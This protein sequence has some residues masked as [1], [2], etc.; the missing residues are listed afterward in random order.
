MIIKNANIVTLNDT[1]IGSIN[2][3]ETILNIDKGN[4]NNSNA[5][6]FEGD[7]LLPG[8]IELHTDNLEK[9]FIPRPNAI[10]PNKI[11]AAIA[12]DNEIV[13]SG[14][15][16]VFDAILVGNYTKIRTS[17]LDDIITSITRGK[18]LGLFKADHHLHYRCELSDPELLETLEKYSDNKYIAL[19]SLMDHTP[20]QRQWRNKEKMLEFYGKG[21]NFTS[22]GAYDFDEKMLRIEKTAKEAE[23]KNRPKVSTI[24]REKKIIMAS[25]D[26]TT[27]EHVNEASKNGIYISEFP[28]TLEAVKQAKKLK[29]KTVLGAPNF[30]RNKSHSDNVSVNDLVDNN[31]DLVDIFS[32]DYV[33]LSLIQSVFKLLHKG[34]NLS[35]S[36]KLVS[37][38]PANSVGLDDRGHIEINKRSDFLRVAFV[39][40]TPLIKEVYIKGKRVN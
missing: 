5:I 40:N 27:E 30:I 16:T 2:F 19:A 31:F 3:N 6:D 39:E 17:I 9:H 22:H 18:D 23:K 1:F 10:W 26:D 4:L 34:V 20:G 37:Y 29:M 33:P 7:Y 13:S 24:W 11:A 21:S 15:T 8:L 14:I 35:E 12:N 28:T 36:T 38:N 32:S 25:H